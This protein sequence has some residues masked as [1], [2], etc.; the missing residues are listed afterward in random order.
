MKYRRILIKLIMDSG[1]LEDNVKEMIT[2][3]FNQ[4]IKNKS[5]KDKN[6]KSYTVKNAICKSV[7]LEERPTDDFYSVSIYLKDYN[8][9]RYSLHRDSVFEKSIDDAIPFLNVEF[10]ESGMQGK[11][12]I[13]LDVDWEIK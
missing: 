10:S 3:L 6:G 11:D 9:N 2:D 12:F 5:F 8:A 1:I 13:N 7:F 4:L